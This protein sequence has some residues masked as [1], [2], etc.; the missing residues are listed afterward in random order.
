MPPLTCILRLKI[1]H[2]AQLLHE[3]STPVTEIAM[4]LGFSGSHFATVFKRHARMTPRQAR[5]LSAPV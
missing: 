5:S 2:A 3:T 4:C 1:E